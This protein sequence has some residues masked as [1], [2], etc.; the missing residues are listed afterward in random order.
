M[1]KFLFLGGLFIFGFFFWSPL[2][3]NGASKK[4]PSPVEMVREGQVFDLEEVGRT[5]ETYFQKIVQDKN[6]RIEIKEVRGYEKILLPPG[7]FSCEVL[8]HEQTHRGGN[9]TATL[10]FLMNGR[11]IKKVRVSARVNIY[12][13]VI[14]TRHFLKRHH[15]IQEADIQRV[16]KNVSLLPQ[17]VIIEVKDILGKRTTISVNGE[18]PLRVGMVEVPPVIKK[19]DRVILLVENPLFK[20]TTLGEA[21]E[22]GRRGD[23][24]K[25]VNLSS[26]K[27]VYGKVLDGNT[28]RI[29][30]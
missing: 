4:D 8:L 22:D 2:Q 21:R 7:A 18:E 12:A 29:D 19:G 30:F 23:R 5:L 28:I 17:D 15:E 24:V 1:K 9:I 27:E 25:L 10:L 16:N 13:D 11:E 3:V 26:K 14:A 6:K 20:I